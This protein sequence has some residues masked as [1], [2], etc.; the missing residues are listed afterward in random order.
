VNEIEIVDLDQSHFKDACRIHVDPRTNRHHPHPPTADDFVAMFA[1]WLQAVETDGFG[2]FAAVENG[3]CIGVGGVCKKRSPAGEYYNN[4]YFRVDADHQGKGVAT[5]LRQA[6][7]RQAASN[8]WPLIAMADAQNGASL[9]M[10]KRLGLVPLDDH[11]L[12]DEGRLVFHL[13]E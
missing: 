6:G 12:E 11:K 13:P 9:H 8:H 10:I 7:L 3:R 2:Y 1:A 5:L 4:L